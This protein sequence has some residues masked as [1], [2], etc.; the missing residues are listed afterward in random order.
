MPN[1]FRF[2]VLIRVML[3]NL[4]RLCHVRRV[5]D[6]H[7]EAAACDDAVELCVPVERLMA[8]APRFKFFLLV[9]VFAVNLCEVA[10]EFFG[11]RRR[12]VRRNRS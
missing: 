9:R 12:N 7:V 2:V 11:E 5:A 3:A 6:N 8:P 10:V 1:K 4:C